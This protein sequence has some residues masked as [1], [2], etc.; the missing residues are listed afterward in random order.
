MY[1]YMHKYVY[2][3]NSVHVCGMC[4][5]CVAVCCTVLHCVAPVAESRPV[6]SAP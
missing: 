3:Y 1:T 2:V 4:V 5:A 6:S